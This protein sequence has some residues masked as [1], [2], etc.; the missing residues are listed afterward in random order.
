MIQFYSYAT[1]CHQLRFGDIAIYYS[2][3]M[4]FAYKTK[5]DT[6]RVRRDMFVG[7][8]GAQ[9]RAHVQ[10]AVGGKKVVLSEKDVF[11]STL[12]EQIKRNILEMAK[13]IAIEGLNVSTKRHVG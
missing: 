3:K 6:L 12:D 11:N 10:L 7:L 13:K 1:D 5:K 2:F 8:W 9:V 4:P